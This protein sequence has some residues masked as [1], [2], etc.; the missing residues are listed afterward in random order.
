MTLLNIMCQFD[1]GL[2]SVWMLAFVS[3]QRHNDR[4][5]LVFQNPYQWRHFQKVYF[6]FDEHCTLC[7]IP[8]HKQKHMLLNWQRKLKYAWIITEKRNINILL[9]FVVYELNPQSIHGLFEGA[10]QSWK[11]FKFDACRRIW[12]MCMP[13]YLHSL[14]KC[15]T[16]SCL[17]YWF[18]ASDILCGLDWKRVNSLWKM[19]INE[20]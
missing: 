11:N 6:V 10:T 16:W 12:K 9:N 3:P 8:L 1:R 19:F 4:R 7:P 18:Y 14:T 5:S 2:T 13:H 17:H 15:P 20:I